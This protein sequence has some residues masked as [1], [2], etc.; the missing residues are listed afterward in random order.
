VN[1]PAGRVTVLSVAVA[2]AVTA[3]VA[4]GVVTT[5]GDRGGRDRAGAQAHAEAAERAADERAAVRA[6]RAFLDRY[7]ADDGRVVRHDQGGDTVSE[8]QA[9][10]LLVAVAVRD[11]DRFAAVW[12]WTR[13]TLQRRDG[14]LSWR[15][16]DG[17]VQDASSAA[18]ADLDAARALV[19][20][21]QAFDDPSYTEA[22]RTLA[23]AVL[24]AE[25]AVTPVGR[26]LLAGSWARDVRPWRVNPSYL[27]PRAT[28]LLR[29]ATGDPRW[30]EVATG[31]RA[32]ATALA[33]PRALPPD[34][35]QVAPDGRVSATAGPD[36]AGPRYGLDAARLV[37]RFA[38]ACAEE[39]RAVAAAVAGTLD[40]PEEG[41]RAVYDLKGEPLVD[42]QHPLGFAAAA[43][44]AGAAG[45]RDA[46]RARLDAADRA[47]QS[48]PV[49]YGAAWAALGRT[50]LRTDL[51]GSCGKPG[52]GLR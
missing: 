30:D 27:S 11:R 4:V 15:W 45:D 22:G 20:G 8:G 12:R 10:A 44:A 9:Y 34:W 7:V 3:S 33:T 41:Q 42:W 24:D 47:E 48:A 19:L 32:V 13:D 51:L 49:Y 37:V 18:D 25:T 1:R 31:S 35:A 17:R 29:H 6:G 52:G 40:R 36:G 26:V 43:A 46:Q 2:L 38:E 23:A 5:G 14:L 50:A 39:D 28:D 21:G 16:A